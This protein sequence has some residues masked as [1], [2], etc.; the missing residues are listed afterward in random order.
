MKLKKKSINKII[1]ST[2]GILISVAVAFP[3]IWLIL[4]SFKSKGETFVYPPTFFPENFTFGNYELLFQVTNFASYFKNSLLVAFS[5]SLV[6]IVVAT[7]GVYSLSRFKFKGQNVI[8]ILL[9]LGYMLP[10]IFLAIPF[11]MF[12]G[13]L[14]FSDNLIALAITLVSITLPFSV[15]MLKSYIESIPLELEEAALVDGATRLK[16]FIKIIVPGA[17]PGIISTFIFTFILA[18]NN[19]MYPLVLIS[20]EKNMTVTLGLAAMTGGMALW[21][22][23]MLAAGSVV[24]TVPVLILFIFIQKRLVAGFTAGAVKG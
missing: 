12:W 1:L 16:A 3:L 13:S 21:S 11:V 4:T 20:S 22:W 24:A 15:W 6:S 14:Q 10:E 9:I 19:Y 18:W 2:L 17:M 8:S 23:G 5:A 7:L